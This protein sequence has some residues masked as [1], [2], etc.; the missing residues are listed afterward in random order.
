MA[1]TDLKNISGY[2]EGLRN[3][4][5]ANRVC[6]IIYDAIQVVRRFP[7]SGKT[8]LEEWTRELVV[9][10]L[11]SYIVTYRV[12]QNDAIQILRIWHGAQQR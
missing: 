4:A 1:I 8:G 10:A 12:M 11:P 2:I 7:E 9:P 6:R 3:L 5:I